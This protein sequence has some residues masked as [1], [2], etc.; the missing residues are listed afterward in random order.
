MSSETKEAKK[1]LAI[2][3]SLAGNTK[4]VA[5]KIRKKTGGHVFGIETVRTYPPEYSSTTEEAKRELQAC[6][7]TSGFCFDG[8]D[9]RPRHQ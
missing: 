2:Y 7:S 9:S 3:Y 6:C 5:E 8:F 4:S 1:V